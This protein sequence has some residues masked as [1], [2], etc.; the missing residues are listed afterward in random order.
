MVLDVP[1]VIAG[2][3]LVGLWAARL[4]LHPQ[5]V[6]WGVRTVLNNNGSILE[7]EIVG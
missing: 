2:P 4:P 1:G 7:T 3:G 5:T 6:T